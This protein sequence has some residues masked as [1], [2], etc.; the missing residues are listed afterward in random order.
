[1]AST[2]SIS[3]DGHTATAAQESTRLRKLGA[4][5][6]TLVSLL[7]VY[8]PPALVLLLDRSLIAKLYLVVGIW[9]IEG[10]AWYWLKS[11]VVDRGDR[12][13]GASRRPD[14]N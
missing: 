7:A 10:I 3:G 11:H 6:R 13:P 12:R 4:H 8:A 9:A 5:F 1:M 2:I 14:Y